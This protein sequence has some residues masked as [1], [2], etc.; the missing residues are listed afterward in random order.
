MR[1][2]ALPGRGPKT[3]TWAAA[4]PKARLHPVLR[5]PLHLALPLPPRQGAVPGEQ[6]W[7]QQK[8]LEDGYGEGKVQIS[9]QNIWVK[10]Q[11]TTRRWSKFYLRVQEKE[12]GDTQQAISSSST[13][14]GWGKLDGKGSHFFYNF[15]VWI[16]FLSLFWMFGYLKKKKV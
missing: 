16:F 11:T 5:V 8:H 1:V 14:G 7:A 12:G 13:S 3:N 10:S 15:P 9:V 6:C 4:V 2:W